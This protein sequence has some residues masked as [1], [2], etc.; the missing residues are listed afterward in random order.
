MSH[1]SPAFNK[2]MSTCVA[3]KLKDVHRPERSFPRVNYNSHPVTK[4]FPTFPENKGS[5]LCL[6]NEK[7]KGGLS[8]YP[9][10]L[11]LN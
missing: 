8:S 6:T 9:D 1:R 11:S 4:T 7:T 2:L 5:L 3:N 10:L